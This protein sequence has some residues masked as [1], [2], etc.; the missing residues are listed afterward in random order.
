MNN[1]L[2]ENIVKTT[3]A[4]EDLTVHLQQEARST[5]NKAQA[6]EYLH[7]YAKAVSLQLDLAQKLKKKIKGEA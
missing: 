1:K 7:L 3:D 2:Y 5:A 4:L 6:K